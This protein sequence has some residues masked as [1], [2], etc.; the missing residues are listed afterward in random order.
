MM[1]KYDEAINA[2]DESIRID[3]L[4]ADARNAKGSSLLVKGNYTEAISCF[5]EAIRIDP[6]YK[7]AWA[8]KSIALKQLN[9][10]SEAEAALTR[11]RELG[12]KG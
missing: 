12:Y 2:S 11:A 6:Q 5:D 8:A 10:T 7:S 1:Q 3:P 4:S 9:R